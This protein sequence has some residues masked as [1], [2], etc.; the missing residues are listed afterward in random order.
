MR[1]LREDEEEPEEGTV[2]ERDGYDRE[3]RKVLQTEQRAGIYAR[4]DIAKEEEI[5]FDYNMDK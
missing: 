2:S 4:R 1:A 5:T 3:Q